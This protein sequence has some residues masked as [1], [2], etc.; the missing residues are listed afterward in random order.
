[1]T[2][3]NIDMREFSRVARKMGIFA[4]DQLPYAI[5]RSLNDTMFRDVR[6][7]ITGPTWAKSF[8]VRNKGLARASMRVETASKGKLSAGVYDALGKADLAKHA[9]GGVKTPKKKVL[10]I[11]VRSR[12]ALHAR[13]KR[14][15]ASVVVKKTPKRALR[16]TSKGIFVGEGGR[17][18]LVYGFKASAALKKRFPFYEDFAMAARRGLATYFPR[19]IQAAVRSAFG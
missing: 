1:M 8:T 19:H 13:G 14:P 3:V 9:R 10:D 6:P 11:P 4:N 17:L 18:H 16:M 2:T 12:V 5:S 15:W 7:Q